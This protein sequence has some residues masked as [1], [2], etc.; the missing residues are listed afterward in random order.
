M[1]V[2]RFSE[3]I[4]TSHANYSI[5]QQPNTV[6]VGI[7]VSNEGPVSAQ[8]ITAWVVWILGG[9]T[10]Y[11]FN[12]TLNINLNPGDTL[13]LTIRVAIPGVSSTGTFNGWLVTRFLSFLRNVF[14][15]I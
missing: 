3:M 14:K 2:D 13:P 10:K 7:T 1:D 4:A 5:P 12:D 6:Q 15:G 9:T 8:I 11:G